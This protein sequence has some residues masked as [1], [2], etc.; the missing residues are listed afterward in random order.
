MADN[1]QAIETPEVEETETE[2]L[3]QAANAEDGEAGKQVEESEQETDE[4]E[5]VLGSAGEPSAE[6]EKQPKKKPRGVGRLLNERKHLKEENSQVTEERDFLKAEVERLRQGGMQQQPTEQQLQIP[7]M[8]SESE[9]N[10]DSTLIASAKE[11]YAKDLHEYQMQLSQQA[12]RTVLDDHLHG[13]QRAEQQQRVKQAIESHYERAEKLKV[14]DYDEAESKLIDVLDQNAVAEIVQAVPNS[15]AV[16]YYLGKNDAAAQKLRET[17]VRNPSMVL[18]ELGGLSKDLKIRPKT[19]K[20]QPAP[21]SKVTGAAPASKSSLEKEIEKER[22]LLA[23][24]KKRD[25]TQ[26]N[27]LKRDLRAAS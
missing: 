4:V 25:F 27:K 20:D 3:Q 22:E 13:K 1:E 21:E 15:E 11:K 9:L 10:F 5:I 2:V 14:S 12:T 7:V 6:E 8:P 17:W 18:F 23:S 16:I 26:L 19:K 24:G